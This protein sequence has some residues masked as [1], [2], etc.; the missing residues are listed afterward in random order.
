VIAVAVLARQHERGTVTGPRI[1]IEPATMDLGVVDANTVVTGQATI[2]NGGDEDLT[3]HRI[4]ATCGCTAAKIAKKSLASGESEKVTVF[5]DSTGYHGRVRKGLFVQANDP[6]G[7]GEMAVT[8]YVKIGLRM[9]TDKV[10][11]GRG[12]SG[13]ILT[14]HA[15]VFRDSGDDDAEIA[16]RNVPDGVEVS[17]GRWETVREFRQ[18]RINIQVSA[19]DKRAGFYETSFQ[20]YLMGI[21]LP[22]TVRYEVIP[23]VECDPTVIRMGEFGGHIEKAVAKL[24]WPAGSRR[25]SGMLVRSVYGNCEATIDSTSGSESHCIVR[26]KAFDE[27]AG[28]NEDMDFLRITYRLGKESELEILTVPVILPAG[29]AVSSPEN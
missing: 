21:Q 19:L 18:C 5:F 13:D 24:R 27:K 28:G 6:R 15:Y 10:F 22:V 25:P 17:E 3:I 4:S 9:N 26:I 12:R 14:G 2:R 8:A 29:K 11:L 1:L 16:F 7:G 20:V 23:H